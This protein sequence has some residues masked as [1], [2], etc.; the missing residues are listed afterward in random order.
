MRP[1]TTVAGVSTGFCGAGLEMLVWLGTHGP[2]PA[3]DGQGRQWGLQPCQV[4]MG[5][6]SHGLTG[7]VWAWAPE[8]LV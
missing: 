5:S 1:G 3:D 4:T 7:G 2:S 6:Q 8:P